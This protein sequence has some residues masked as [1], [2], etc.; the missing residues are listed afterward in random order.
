MPHLKN[1]QKRHTT[2]IIKEHNA[3]ANPL[4]FDDLILA[5]AKNLRAQILEQLDGVIARTQQRIE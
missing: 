4:A 3:E 1:V 5:S 2:T